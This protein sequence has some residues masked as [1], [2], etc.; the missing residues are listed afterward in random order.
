MAIYVNPI[1]GKMS[2]TQSAGSV[3]IGSYNPGQS[4]GS[5]NYSTYSSKTGST[6]YSKTPEEALANSGA[7]WEGT[8]AL[9]NL[10]QGA[11]T[12]AKVNKSTY[13]IYSKLGATPEQIGGAMGGTGNTG[14]APGLTPEQMKG[15]SVP[16]PTDK[17]IEDKTT[18]ATPV[19]EP[20][21]EE[22]IE[23][24]EPV[25]KTYSV[26]GGD[27]MSAIARKSGMSLGELVA[28]NPH[29]TNPN[30]IKPGDLLNLNDKAG[31]K[32]G[33]QPMDFN[34]PSDRPELGMTKSQEL[35]SA[36]DK[37][38][39]VSTNKDLEYAWDRGWRPS[40][41]RDDAPNSPA[42]DLMKDKGL[43][44]EQIKTVFDEYQKNPEK[45]FEELYQ[46]M[47]TRLGLN[48]LKDNISNLTKRLTESEEKY[49]DEI[50]KVNENPWMS[51]GLR[52]MRTK[53]IQE[54]AD[55]QKSIIMQEL[56]L[57]QDAFDRGRQEVQYL[58]TTSLNQWNADRNFDY[59][60]QQ[61][62]INR[63]ERASERKEDTALS[64]LL[65]G[66]TKISGPSGLKGLEE[67][68]IIRLPNGDIYKKPPV[69][70]EADDFQFVAGTENQPGGIFNKT[71]GEFQTFG[72]GGPDDLF[73]I[74]N[75]GG[76]C[77]DYIHKVVDNVPSLG[78]MYEDK[79]SKSNVNWNPNTT[80]PNVQVGDV[81]IQKT[82]M[83]Y[84]HV[85]VVTGV[86]GGKIQVLESNWGLDEKIGTRVLDVNDKNIT[87]I[88]R[89]GTMKLPSTT[90]PSVSQDAKGWAD[91]IKNG[92]ATIANV[93]DK[94]RTE[95][96]NALSQMPQDTKSN[97]D[98]IEKANTAKKLASDN[99]LKLA[100]G[101]T[102]LTRTTFSFS[103]LAKKQDF[104]ASVEQ[105]ISDL[106]LESLISAK[107]RGATFGAL[108]DREMRVLS[109]S[110]T[111]LGALT[112]TD[113]NGNI[114]GFKGSE[115]SFKTELNKISDIFLKASGT[116]S[117]T[118]NISEKV[119]K[120]GYDYNKMKAD[121]FSDEEIKKSLNIK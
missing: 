26:V 101:T 16:K 118:N 86:E 52:S 120:L 77:G 114:K 34:V 106:S 67:D 40:I 70:A 87:G 74:G 110:A 69:V 109:A 95:V 50:Q 88:Y 81:L 93:P 111:K 42:G 44:D 15:V 65:N 17:S 43:E 5:G 39:R 94:I 112:V 56:Q 108:S 58:T 51:E 105:L 23:Q 53:R 24:P 13:D 59:N 107:E 4:V 9:E 80:T 85:S 11:E 116:T 30:V 14:V 25:A 31:V 45:T 63:A 27:T 38:D 60:Q 119:S 61:D 78:N 18:L 55:A 99:A 3:P 62:L 6:V 7:N 72:D 82:N 97:A 96:A 1:T 20:K 104:I 79:L 8:G 41:T 76:Q 33:I 36:W 113:K 54:R 103:D 22:S 90:T 98:A 48:D 71:T 66:Y 102:G 21:K 117:S 47:Y 12:Q 75:T 32:A 10:K 89:G 92:G 83:P 68:D 91:L 115:E 46:E 121:G 28:L 57:N 37:G 29:I 49:A 100:V 2:E 35:Q 73:T 64:L 84:G 19:N